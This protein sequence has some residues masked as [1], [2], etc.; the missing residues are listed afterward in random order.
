MN[1]NLASTSI[2]EVLKNP[3]QFAFLRKIGIENYSFNQPVGDERKFVII[4]FETT[5][6]K[7]G[8]DEAI[9]IGLTLVSY[10]PSK[11]Q[12]TA[13]LENYQAFECPSKPITDE[14]ITITGI[15]QDMVNGHTFDDVKIESIIQQAEFMSAHNASF[16]RPFFA[17]RFP[18][19]DRVRWACSASG[20]DWYK[21]FYSSR[22]LQYLA[23]KSNF[24][25]EPHRAC[26]DTCA[27]A[28]LLSR[29]DHFNDLL[30]SLERNT[31]RVTV[32]NAPVEELT[33]LN[34]KRYRMKGTGFDM[35]WQ[36][37][38]DESKLEAENLWLDSFFAQG[39][40]NI[41]FMTISAD[42]RFK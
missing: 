33:A 21:K 12:M 5:G 6:F 29:S 25:Y 18:K 34:S 15:T 27:T 2:D 20:I 16:D 28:V 35:Y 41:E 11:K 31:V 38:I 13:I 1:L 26:S 9:E 36:K 4:D 24:T 23:M 32:R 42:E 39:S 19:L 37:E 30:D 40:N 3:D 14:T 10:S 22:A 8:K 17:H 7:A